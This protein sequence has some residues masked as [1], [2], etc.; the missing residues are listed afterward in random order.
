MNDSSRHLPPPWD[1]EIHA[2]EAF[3]EQTRSIAN[4]DPLLAVEVG[5]QA[6][7]QAQAR[8]DVEASA[9]AAL[10]IAIAE[11]RVGDANQAVTMQEA[12]R[13]CALSQDARLRA[14]VL[15]GSMH[16]AFNRGEYARALELANEGIL[17]SQVLGLATPLKVFVNN[18]AATLMCVNEHDAA[19]DLLGEARRL[20]S[21]DATNAAY[22]HCVIDVNEAHSRRELARFCLENDRVNE[23]EKQRN[24]GH[25]AARRGFDAAFGRFDV[26]SV[27]VPLDELV[28]A[29]LA[30]GDHD[31]A[32]EPVRAVEA[33]YAS[34][35]RPGSYA[36]GMFGVTLS[37]VEA[38]DRN[39][40]P[41][42]R[43]HRLEAMSQ[44]EYPRLRT[45]LLRVRM[46]RLLS[47]AY[48]AAGDYKAALDHHKRFTEEEG[49]IKS[50]HARE[51]ARVLERTQSALRGELIEFITHDLRT[52]LAAALRQL[53]S[54][55]ER[56]P[57]PL[58]SKEIASAADAARRAMAMADQALGMMR[59]EYMTAS[60]MTEVNLYHLADDVC[61]QLTSPSS[62]APKLIRDL[63]SV[64]MILGDRALLMRA[65]GNLID[66]A[67]SHAPQGANVLV[68]LR[69]ADESVCL[70]VA[71]EGVGMS[72]SVRLR[73]FRRYASENA[74]TGHGLGLALVSRVARLH[75]ARIE[76]E[77]APGRG[78]KISMIFTRAEL[79]T[80]T[81]A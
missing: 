44:L 39:A 53:D 7:R 75:G 72:E 36:W 40:K 80:G 5:R 4:T 43:V 15:I 50:N 28:L 58:D 42:Q 1:G 31:V 24:W 46:L 64:P 79:P 34:A 14:H 17:S 66:N 33:R 61:E 13:L 8:S 55:L 77:S 71:D 68:V 3:F 11:G 78:T 27:L 62:R 51:R 52:P 54:T 48:E 30:R 10:R 70:S 73:L 6:L 23:A 35:L 60:E 32:W 45:G 67:M 26:H 19:L 76:V 47:A 12:E 63:E 21:V 29:L 81:P 57:T 20:I 2:D 16:V 25:A 74:S 41:A 9:W 69:P 37:E 22:E 65:L 59:A 49:R 18:A 38:A 56:A